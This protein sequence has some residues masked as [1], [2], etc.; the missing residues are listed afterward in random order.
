MKQQRFFLTFCTIGTLLMALSFVIPLVATV[1]QSFSSTLSVIPEQ[2]TL[3][4]YTL[5]FNSVI[6]SLGVTLL[7][8]VCSSIL[9]L[10]YTLPAVYAV[11]RRDFRGRGLLNQMLIL[12]ILI[13]GIVLGLALMQLFKG[14]GLPPITPL[15][16]LIVIHSVMAIPFIA[17]PLNASFRQA[18][19]TL[20]EAAKT[21]GADEIVTFRDVIIPSITPG[22]L[23]GLFLAFS[24]ST[25]DFV[26]T[27]FFA[28]PDVVPL[29]VRVYQS[30]SYGL[31]QLTSAVTVTLLVVSLA[32]V[33]VST[34]VLKV[35]LQ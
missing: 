5:K 19:V 25:G 27:L 20:E 16:V 32:Y 23:S 3:K 1:L 18:D 9:S 2:F 10:L 29:S 21:L 24:R 7:I 28:T 14:A 6:G 34:L 31:P 33:L 30:T 11:A 15:L 26:V 12:P 35:D 13:P 4:W 22:I 17:R 8:A